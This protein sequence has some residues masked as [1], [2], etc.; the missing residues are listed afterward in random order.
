[1]GPIVPRADSNFNFFRM[2]KNVRLFL[3]GFSFYSVLSFALIFLSCFLFQF[4]AEAQAPLAPQ[5]PPTLTLN[6]NAQVGSIITVS[7]SNAPGNVG[8]RVGL[9]SPSSSPS[10]LMEWKY[11]D[12]LPTSSP[13]GMGPLR[14]HPSNPRY[15]QNSS[16]KAVYLSGSTFGWGLPGRDNNIADFISYLD[17][18]K[19]T[20]HNLVRLW[21]NESTWPLTPAIPMPWRRTG[22]GKALDN[23]LRFDLNQFDPAFFDDLRNRALEA[24]R[25]GIYIMVMLFQ[26]FSIDS[27]GGAVDDA[28]PYHPFNSSNN[29]NG[30]NGDL[31]GDGA[32]TE[33]HTLAN[34]TITALQKGYVE[35]TIDTLNDLD[36]VI[37][38]IA[39][40]DTESHA[41]NSWRYE[42]INHIKSYEAGKPKQHP[43]VLTP[44]AYG[45]GNYNAALFSSPA[46]AISPGNASYRDNP[47]AATGNKVILADS[48]H[49]EAGRKD[50]QFIWQHFLRG[51]NTILLDLDAYPGPATDSTWIPIRSA[52]K[53]TRAYSKRM[54][55]AATT[56]QNCSS[57]TQYCLANPGYEYLVYQPNSE[58]TFTVNLLEGTYTYEW[59]NPANSTAAQTGSFTV[60]AGDRSFT[61]PFAGEAVLYVQSSPTTSTRPKSN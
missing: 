48:D 45:G 38:E 22:P 51:N 59:F 41:N 4:N 17:L 60:S 35:K 52:I 3:A 49:L 46:D 28:W 42:M 5:L 44:H 11:L 47:P 20:D 31:D 12:E 24:R 23:H 50:P 13:T 18:I 27:K 36:N 1:V 25:R 55:M 34:P 19:S 40:E 37:F 6:S 9:F 8:D 14:V 58:Q 39:N 30:I 10:Q 7:V 29:I 21:C 43:V 32:G 61:A 15:F 16:G 26:G 53:D 56:P 57:S 54:N 2:H 33:V